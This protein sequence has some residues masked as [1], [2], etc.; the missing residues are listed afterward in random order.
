MQE[1]LAAV[2]NL[3]RSPG[4]RARLQRG[5]ARRFV[6]PRVAS[7]PV[8]EHEPRSDAHRVLEGTRLHHHVGAPT[9]DR[10]FGLRRGTGRLH[11]KAEQGAEQAAGGGPQQIRRI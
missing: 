10:A 1:F 9:H 8:G 3:A 4:Y 11:E 7:G 6:A 5:R 2:R